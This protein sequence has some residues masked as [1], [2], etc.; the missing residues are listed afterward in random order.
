MKIIT[1]NSVNNNPKI[2]I[3]IDEDLPQLINGENSLYRGS[4]FI[5]IPE[6][7]ISA[8]VMDNF[9]KE[10]AIISYRN[11]DSNL[12]GIYFFCTDRYVDLTIDNNFSIEE[13][14]VYNLL[15]I[16]IG[17]PLS[18]QVKKETCV[19]SISVFIEKRLLEKYFKQIVLKN[20]TID[21]INDKGKPSLIYN[22]YI[23]DYS[24][25]L[26]NEFRKIPKSSPFYQMYFNGLVYALIRDFIITIQGDNYF[27]QNN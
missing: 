13:N 7:G 5:S 3:A 17:L 26:I 4:H 25:E 16:D 23:T 27:I 14:K 8:F 12:V 22:N 6:S 21:A 19:F 9:Y 20:P 1:Y 10:D 2:T 24:L 15:L 11:K 18:Y